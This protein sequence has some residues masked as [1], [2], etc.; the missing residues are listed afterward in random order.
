MQRPSI[1]SSVFG[2]LLWLVVC[3]AGGFVMLARL[4]EYG[5]VVQL[6]IGTVMGVL[7]ALTHVLLPISDR[8][9]RL[10]FVRRG[11]LNWLSA[12]LLLLVIAALLTNYELARTNPGFWP[13]AAELLLLY[14]GAPMLCLA[15]LVALLTSMSGGRAKARALA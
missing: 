10:G 15:L 11:L 7:G 8:F 13:E 2:A 6:L 1:W 5:S 4:G 14:T 3:I 9:R 12:Y